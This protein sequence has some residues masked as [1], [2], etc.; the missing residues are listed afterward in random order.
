MRSCATSA[1]CPEPRLETRR[2]PVACVPVT[3]PLAS[4]GRSPARRERRTSDVAERCHGVRARRRVASPS[5]ALC[6][7]PQP[8]PPRPGLAGALALGALRAADRGAAQASPQSP[9]RD[10]G[11]PRGCEGVGRRTPQRAGTGLL[12][13]GR[14]GS[15]MGHLVRRSWCFY[16]RCS[17]SL[18]T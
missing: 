14:A 8:V 10:G 6:V 9:L 18:K 5:N 3:R 4:R 1:S 11:E 15:P 7:L 2:H 17:F 12:A 13:A 16:L